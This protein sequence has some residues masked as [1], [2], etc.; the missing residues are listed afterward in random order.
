MRS[1]KLGSIENF[2][3]L[4]HNSMNMSFKQDPHLTAKQLFVITK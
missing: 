1:I 2:K 3:V 4:N